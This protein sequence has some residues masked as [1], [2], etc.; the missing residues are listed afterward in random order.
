MLKQAL[1]ALIQEKDFGTLRVQDITDRADLGRATFYLHYSDK[2][3]LLSAIVD[4]SYQEM[5]ERL[6]NAKGAEN[7]IGLRWGLEYAAENPELF[8][9]LMGHQR[10]AN[11]I[12]SLI[13]DRVMSELP[14]KIDNDNLARATAHILAG[15]IMGVFNW[16]LHHQ[17][18]LTLD[19][20]LDLF[21]KIISEGFTN[22]NNQ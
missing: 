5:A 6:E 7:L 21:G 2:E 9:V 10:T 20:L 16:W 3:D 1:I 11:K 19:E 13:I 14:I 18:E 22:I 15:S 12:R 4:Q 8:S 17:N